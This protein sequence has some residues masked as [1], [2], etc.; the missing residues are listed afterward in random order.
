M[1]FKDELDAILAGT[2]EDKQVLLFSATMP[3]E[4]RHIASKYMDS[5]QEVSGG[6]A[7]KSNEMIT[8][9]YYV[10]S[11]KDRYNAL[12]RIA[13]VNPDIYAII[14]AGPRPKR[15]KSPTNWGTMVT[16]P[17]LCTV[18]FHRHSATM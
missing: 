12:K 15:R 13:D 16:M 3:D 7:N 8:H 10:V 2:P 17:T 4:I 6:R 5:P 14:F 9:Y 1:G 11:A 18:I